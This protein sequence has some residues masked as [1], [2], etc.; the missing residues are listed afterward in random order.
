MKIVLHVT[1]KEIADFVSGIQNRQVRCISC[2]KRK[3]QILKRIK[4]IGK[5]SIF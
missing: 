5:N 2:E 1:T 4:R 3:K